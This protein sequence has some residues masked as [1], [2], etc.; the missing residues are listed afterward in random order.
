L[1]VNPRST[2]S[3]LALVGTVSLALAQ[4]G[5]SRLAT[6][7]KLPASATTLG[8]TATA[9]WT[10]NI[11]T[12]E[13][14]GVTGTGLTEAQARVRARGAA[15]A[16]AQR[17]LAAA[18][19]GVQVTSETTVETYELKSD[20]IKTR[21]EA[22]LKGVRVVPG[23]DS[24]EKLS[25]G[26]FIYSI[27]VSLPLAGNDSV[28]SIIAPEIT[29]KQSV[30]KSKVVRVGAKTPAKLVRGAR[31][32][33]ISVASLVLTMSNPSFE[34]CL[35]P[36]VVSESGVVLWGNFKDIPP[37]AVNQGIMGYAKT[38]IPADRLR[39]RLGAD[40]DTLEVDVKTLKG[41]C[42]MVISDADAKVIQDKNKETGFLEKFSV[43]VLVP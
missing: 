9:D 18:V 15:I 11:I 16:D 13:G 8:Q 39:G 19:R 21:I 12:A 23:S 22:F 6:N 30:I 25:D 10:N 4:P 27:S 3:L 33:P 31:G 14:K 29:N 41:S 34:P 42:D 1:F 37:T 17:L 43:A 32:T 40:A 24:I 38:Q 28:T 5:P 7:I 35:A 2:L 20:A 26:S 36:K